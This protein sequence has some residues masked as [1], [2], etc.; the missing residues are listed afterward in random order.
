MCDAWPVPFTPN[1]DGANDVVWFE[2][3]EMEISGA[4]LEIFDIEGRRVF[5]AEIPPTSPERDAFWNGLRES[6]T[7]AIPGSYIYVISRGVDVVCK[8]AIVLA[9]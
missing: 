6:G 5:D 9:R 4:R 2:Y 8:G 1:E 3:P 7:K